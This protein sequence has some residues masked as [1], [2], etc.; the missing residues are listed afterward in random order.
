M[1]YRVRMISSIG[2]ATSVRRLL[3]RTVMVIMALAAVGH[4][5]TRLSLHKVHRRASGSFNCRQR[6][7]CVERAI[8]LQN[9]S[10]IF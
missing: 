5:R 8:A 1:T 6:L 10:P 2:P 4:E 9:Y 7:G 3:R